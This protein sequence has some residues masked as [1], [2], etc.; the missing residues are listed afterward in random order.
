MVD[1]Y[2]QKR[3]TVRKWKERRNGI[4]SFHE[5]MDLELTMISGIC[6]L[7]KWMKSKCFFAIM[8]SNYRARELMV[9]VR[10]INGRY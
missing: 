8:N 6:P 7:M 3:Y 2:C 1:K 5:Q 9:A 10:V 4:I